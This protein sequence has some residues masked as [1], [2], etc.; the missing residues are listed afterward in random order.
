L[1]INLGED[2]LE[3]IKVRA[4]FVTTLS[5]A[6]QWQIWCESS[7]NENKEDKNVEPPEVGEPH[8]VYALNSLN[9]GRHLNIP[10][11]I[12]ELAAE[13]LFTSD[14]DHITIATMVLRSILASPIDVRR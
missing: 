12:R 14:N 7:E 11:C 9:G 1:D 2:I 5:R 8:F 3:D 13:P 10:S 6:R 4:C